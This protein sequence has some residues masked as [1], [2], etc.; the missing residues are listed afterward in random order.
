MRPPVDEQDLAAHVLALISIESFAA[1]R[2]VLVKQQLS[3]LKRLLP[4]QGCSVGAA[5]QDSQQQC[6]SWKIGITKCDKYFIKAPKR[7]YCEAVDYITEHFGDLG[8]R[9]CNIN[10][11]MFGEEGTPR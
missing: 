2:G 6:S 1:G 3:K 7:N 5:E 4:T 10:D 8:Q 11:V 9:V